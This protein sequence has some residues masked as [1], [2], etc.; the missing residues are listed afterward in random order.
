MP[1]YGNLRRRGASTCGRPR[2]HG[3]AGALA[4]FAALTLLCAPARSQNLF[5]ADVNTRVVVLDASGSMERRTSVDQAVFADLAKNSTK[6]LFAGFEQEGDVAAGL[7][8][9]G[10]NGDR[11]DCGDYRMAHSLR[12]VDAQHKAA[13]DATIDGIRRYGATPLSQAME[14]AYGELPKGGGVM[15][16]ISDFDKRNQCER[17]PC[18][19]AREL[20]ARGYKEGRP[21]DVWFVIAIGQSAERLDRLA[22]CVDG[23]L[24]EVTSSDKVEPV[25][26]QILDQMASIQDPAVVEPTSDDPRPP[27]VPPKVTPNRLGQA[28]SLSGEIETGAPELFAGAAQASAA[29]ELRSA[30]GG[31]VTNGGSRILASSLKPGVYD[32]TAIVGGRRKTARAE[33]QAKEETKVRFYFGAPVVDIVALVNGKTPT[34][35]VTWAVTN[36]AGSTPVLLSGAHLLRSAAPGAYTIE[37]TLA[38]VTKRVVTPRLDWGDHFE[39]ELR[40]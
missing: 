7:A 4:A 22:Q 24:Y 3:L 25:V 8:V 26:T 10:D 6:R 34:S 33:V 17:D 39:H 29:L 18:K 12:R 16:L 9:L 5:E 1:A 27:A 15:I 11:G 31:A 35:D 38:G 36:G 30:S 13:V 32:L 40:F 14:M 21:L 37:A 28:G 20:V 23:W 19:K 2:R